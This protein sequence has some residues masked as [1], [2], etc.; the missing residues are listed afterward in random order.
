[1]ITAEKLP[2]ILE[3]ITSRLVES[4]E[5]RGLYDVVVQIAME[6]TDAQACSLYLERTGIDEEESPA[7]IRMVSGAGFELHRIGVEYERGEGLTGTIWASSK[8]VKYDTTEEVE[9]PD[10]GWKGR[11]NKMVLERMSDWVCYSLIGVPLKIGTHTIGVLKVENK[12]PGPGSCFSDEDQATLEVIASTIA[13]AIENQRG[14]EESYGLILTALLAVTEMLV[15][16]ETTTFN[17]LCDSIVHKC[18]DVFN[19]EACSL[20]LADTRAPRD[21]EPEH[22]VMVSGAGYERFRRGARYRR[23]QGLTGTIWA[24]SEPVKYDTRQE[25]ENRAHGWLGVHNDEV[26]K[27]VANWG[28]TSLIGVPLR[29]GDRTIGVLKVE[30]KRPV[31]QSHFSINERRSLEILAANIA[32]SLE[33]RRHHQ[34]LFLKGEAA[35]DFTHNS[36]SKIQVAQLSIDDAHDSLAQGTATPEEIRR[37]LEQAK[38]ALDMLAKDLRSLREGGSSEPVTVSLSQILDTIVDRCEPLLV[39][40]GIALHLTPVESDVFINVN[41]DQILEAF[42]NLIGNSVEALDGRPSPQIWLKA[43]LTTAPDHALRGAPAITILLVD[44]G[45]G[46]SEEQQREFITKHRI[47]SEKHGGFGNGVFMAY[48]CLYDNQIDLRIVDPPPDMT[49]TGAAFRIDI[50][51]YEPKNLRVLIID[52]EEVVLDYFRKKAAETTNVEVDYDTTYELLQSVISGDSDSAR[53]RAALMRY[54]RILLDCHFAERLDG[55]TLVKQLQLVDSRLAARIILMSGTEEYKNRTDVVVI[56]K[57]QDIAKRFPEFL[58]EL[59]TE[60]A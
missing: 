43:T 18:L 27:R 20:Y 47:P 9:D 22:I 3:S 35:R 15:G 30:N 40:R 10:K 12:N 51:A 53:A 54:D 58:L 38:H 48:S 21:F 5:P 37:D 36:R 16:S 2:Q 31:G 25:V 13:L 45:P 41:R 46:F 4:E 24:K 42:D 56:D 29:I 6:T 50:L 8:S 60:G 57:F 34:G 14:A 17:I 32:L 33:M 28:C 44:N 49:E 52:D 26:K 39:R 59:Q 7:K 23:G 19:A 11:H 1:M 55:P